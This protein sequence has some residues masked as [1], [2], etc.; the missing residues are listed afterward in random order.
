V[1]LAAATVSAAVR[2]GELDDLCTEIADRL[3]QTAIAVVV[4]RTEVI[5][6]VEHV[7]N[8]SAPLEIVEHGRCRVPR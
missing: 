2:R 7:A 5:D 4:I 1:I 8:G 6:V 3:A